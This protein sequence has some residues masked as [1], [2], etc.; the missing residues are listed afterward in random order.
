[1]S[2]GPTL[3]TGVPKE[4]NLQAREAQDQPLRRPGSLA[5]LL[6][7][8]G[9]P[10]LLEV[11][12]RLLLRVGSALVLRSHGFSPP[13]S[14]DLRSARTARLSQLPLYRA[15]PNCHRVSFP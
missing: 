2:A 6:R 4:R 8:F 13:P 9:L 7:L 11:V 5:R 1:M 3:T 14:D 15:A 10:L 12:L